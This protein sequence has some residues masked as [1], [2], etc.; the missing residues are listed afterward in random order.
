VA[1]RIITKLLDDLDG[2][3][4]TETVQFAYDGREYT[5]DLSAKN[6]AKLRKA[7]A[8][9]VE[10]GAKVTPSRG[11]PAA[12]RF[13]KTAAG[14]RAVREWASTSGKFP[15]LGERGRIPADVVDAYRAAS[16]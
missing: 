9:Y 6:A 8:P 15:G 10:H 13:E 5:I 3:D 16:G 7:L 2:G 1:V 4:A 11:R 14:R 12:V